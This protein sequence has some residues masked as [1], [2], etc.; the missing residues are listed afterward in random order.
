MV[1]R[2]VPSSLRAPNERTPNRKPVM[3]HDGV[4]KNVVEYLGNKPEWRI[5]ETEMILPPMPKEEDFG[6]TKYGI[7][8]RADVMSWNPGGQEFIIFECKAS[9]SDFFRDHKFVDYK[10]WC[11]LFSFAVPEELATA[12][13][14]RMEESP[15]LY[16]GVGLL[17][18]PNDFG[19]RR[20]IRKPVRRDWDKG[21][22]EKM[23]ERWAMSCH[24]RLIGTRLEIAQ[25]KFE[26]KS[27]RVDIK[28]AGRY[29]LHDVYPTTERQS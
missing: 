20:M 9:W 17:V 16:E 3:D 8:R 24:N 22:Y 10:K 19:N 7:E 29:G 2:Q 27:L 1:R 5:A 18:I 6:R 26:I 4:I 12:A 14:L 11:N 28:H 13:R 25:L 23:T 21:E 15:D